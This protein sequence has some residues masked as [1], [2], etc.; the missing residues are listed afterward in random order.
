MADEDDYGPSEDQV[1]AWNIHNDHADDSE[2][3]L[4]WLC[5]H[6][7]ANPGEPCDPDCADYAEEVKFYQSLDEAQADEQASLLDQAQGALMGVAYRLP[8]SGLLDDPP[9]RQG[10]DPDVWLAKLAVWM[11]GYRALLAEQVA[12]LE[13]GN[14]RAIALQLEKDVVRGF[15]T[16]TGGAA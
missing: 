2:R 11:E 8:Y 14:R 1:N 15:L 10:V 6:C 13:A 12:K 3:W 4:G 5:E 16:G 9:I 7:G